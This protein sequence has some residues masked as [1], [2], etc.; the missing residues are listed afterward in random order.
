LKIFIKFS[1]ITELQE[2]KNK[3]EKMEKAQSGMS[4]IKTLVETFR[5]NLPYAKSDNWALKCLEEVFD[6]YNMSPQGIAYER[7][8]YHFDTNLERYDAK[9]GYFLRHEQIYTLGSRLLGRGPSFWGG[10]I[11]KS[12]NDEKYYRIIVS[13]TPV[14]KD[15]SPSEKYFFEILTN[16]SALGGEE[17]PIKYDIMSCVHSIINFFNTITVP[18]M[19]RQDGPCFSVNL[20]NKILLGRFI[21]HLFNDMIVHYQSEAG[22]DK[23]TTCHLAVNVPAD[24]VSPSRKE[25]KEEPEPHLLT[26]GSNSL[27]TFYLFEVCLADSPENTLYCYIRTDE[28]RFINYKAIYNYSHYSYFLDREVAQQS[29]N[30]ISPSKF[31]SDGWAISRPTNISHHGNP[32]CSAEPSSLNDTAK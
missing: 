28:Y 6:I 3:K 11:R 27:K 8:P 14:D 16:T 13:P 24:F 29:F 20:G 5:A 7:H 12:L 31:H 30:S 18:G 9:S 22:N 17:T 2:N 23:V 21:K 19:A 26:A 15:N 25:D 4:F 32:C 10:I 1:I